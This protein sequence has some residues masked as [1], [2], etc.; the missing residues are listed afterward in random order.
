M[1][2]FLTILAFCCF[3]HL[4]DAHFGKCFSDAD[5]KYAP[6]CSHFGWCGSG[7]KYCK[8]KPTIDCSNRFPSM[9]FENFWQKDLLDIAENGFAKRFNHLKFQTNRYSNKL[10]VAIIGSGP[11]GLTAAYE[12]AL[13]AS[14]TKAPVEITIIEKENR[15][16]GRI[17]TVGKNGHFLPNI[18]DGEALTDAGAMRLPLTP[19]SELDCRYKSEC[20]KHGVNCNVASMT[21][22]EI[23]HLVHGTG[24]YE[25]IKSCSFPHFLIRHYVR[26][27]HLPVLRHNFGEVA[28]EVLGKL[29]IK[30]EQDQYICEK[31][32]EGG[33][34][35]NVDQHLL[36]KVE[37][38]EPEFANL[39]K[40][41]HNGSLSNAFETAVDLEVL[42]W[43][44]N[45]S[46][47]ME[48]DQSKLPQKLEAFK[49]F[50]DDWAMTY[51]DYLKT[52]SRR[53]SG[54]GGRKTPCSPYAKECTPCS[55][56]PKTPSRHRKRHSTMKS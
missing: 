8:T 9:Q 4:C 51:R 35:L 32:G 34:D 30:N 6:C 50:Q 27:F 53:R 28:H 37:R 36:K 47:I 23:Q 10:R 12:L 11:A 25:F 24:G 41:K 40:A 20:K 13:F 38:L 18:W 29:F 48:T 39:L 3:G 33:E 22:D 2:L 17:K 52:S 49:K 1:K 14:E 31:C 43:V 42:D 5:C 45:N 56:S 44:K 15:I 26:K 54:N 16:G 19:Q 21:D 46:V 7:P 55:K